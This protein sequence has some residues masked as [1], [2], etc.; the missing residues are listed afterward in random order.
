MRN[1]Y[2]SLHRAR[3]TTCER[4]SN[5]ALTSSRKVFPPTAEDLPQPET[6]KETPP[7]IEGST[8]SLPLDTQ[9]SSLVA[10]ADR[11]ANNE[12]PGK[13]K[14]KV[15]NPDVEPDDWETIEKPEEFLETESAAEKIEAKSESRVRKTA[16][17][18]IPE[19][20]EEKPAAEE[21]EAS[22]VG[23]HEKNSLLKDW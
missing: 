18:A 14:L 15:I 22:A 1:W 4:Y 13:K 11:S 6:A 8:S 16:G 2:R 7:V 10:A 3:D 17:E 20:I 19:I 12:E 23:N 9:A 21:K 5:S